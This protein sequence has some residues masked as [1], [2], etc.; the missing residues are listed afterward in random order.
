MHA[1]RATLDPHSNLTQDKGTYLT[2]LNDYTP[3]MQA[4]T[5]LSEEQF[6]F[7][8]EDNTWTCTKAVK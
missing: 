2:A 8:L 3:T 6:N 1:S 4:S 5:H 7:D